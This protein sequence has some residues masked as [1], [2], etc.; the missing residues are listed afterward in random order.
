MKIVGRRAKSR[1]GGG[2]ES[3]NVKVQPEIF[4]WEFAIF[5]KPSLC[6]T[7]PLWL[8]GTSKCTSE[9]LCTRTENQGSW[10]R[11]RNL[12][13]FV[14]IQNM[15]LAPYIGCVVSNLSPTD[16]GV[17]NT[18]RSKARS[19]GACHLWEGIWNWSQGLCLDSTNIVSK[20]QG[21]NTMIRMSNQTS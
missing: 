5:W 8:L 19:T 14:W 1:G 21:S 4:P 18:T 15:F 17:E 20:A 9:P 10:F 13:I 3:E 2:R 11:K 16:S 12:D 6:D 7:R